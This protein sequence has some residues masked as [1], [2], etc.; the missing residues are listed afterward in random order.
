M[1]GTFDRGE[2]YWVSVDGSVG[3]EIQTGRPAV[4]IS[5]TGSNA[6][7]DTVIIAYLDSSTEKRHPHIVSVSSSG[8]I[9]KV[10]CNQI[11]T[12]SKRRFTKYIGKLSK[13]DMSRVTGAL[14]SAMCIP[15]PS[16]KIENQTVIAEDKQ[17]DVDLLVERDMYKRMYEKVLGE[18]VHRRVMADVGAE[19]VV[20]VE[21][22]VEEPPKKYEVE[23]KPKVVKEEKPEPKLDINNCTEKDLVKAGF[24]SEVAKNVVMLQ[25]YKNV[26]ELK[27]VPGVT[28]TWFRVVRDR[29]TCTVKQSNGK[30]NVNTATVEEMMVGLGIGRLTA[31]A[32]RAYRKKHGRFEKVD[33]LLNV[34]RFG[35]GCM[36]KFGPMIE[37]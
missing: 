17:P 5:G 20:A 10:L 18:L 12:V 16:G 35:K 36:R 19:K 21:R 13:D 7:N 34:Q 29:L 25:P 31:E 37:V 33:D 3:S 32:I 15:L 4:V 1:N 28:A 24:N 26:D 27:E 9:S 14:A 30:V 22:I 23:K 11:R 6:E 8:R 2:I